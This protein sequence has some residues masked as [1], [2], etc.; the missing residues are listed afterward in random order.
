M[1]QVRAS[2]VIDAPAHEVWALLTEF[3]QWPKWGPTVRRV[4]SD[5]R[6]V[7]PGVTGRVKAVAGPWL[8]FEITE[9]EPL[10]LWR[11]KVAGVPATGHFLSE[12]EDG[13]VL[14]EFTVPAI[15]APYGLIL[16]AGLRRL[17]DLAE[18]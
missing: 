4:Q 7:G 3:E 5:A 10:R 13:K 11:W 6:G 9:L 16:R 8:P 15:L 18:G 12:L 14:V 17:K 2:V 1:R